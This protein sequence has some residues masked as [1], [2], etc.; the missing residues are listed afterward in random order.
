MN[1]A[2]RIF[3][4]QSEPQ[5]QADAWSR[6]AQRFFACTAVIVPKHDACSIAIAG[7]ERDVLGRMRGES[8]L[9]DALAAENRTGF[10]GLYDLA[11]RRCPVIWLVTRESPT[12]RTALLMAAILASVCLGPILGDDALFGV[13]TAREKLERL[14]LTPRDR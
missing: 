3:S 12:D 13:R 1:Q 4:Q 7:A 2:W 11:G 5:V 9:R 10:T 6:A 8:D 14:D